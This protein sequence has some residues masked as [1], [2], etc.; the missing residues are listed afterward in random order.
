MDP[1][2]YHKIHSFTFRHQK[3]KKN[4]IFVLSFFSVIMKKSVSAL[5]FVSRIDVKH[6]KLLEG[7]YYISPPGRI[8]LSLCTFINSMLHLLKAWQNSFIATSSLDP[9]FCV[10][11]FQ[12]LRNYSSWFLKGR[13][14]S[15]KGNSTDTCWIS[16]EVLSLV[17]L[18]QQRLF[19]TEMNLTKHAFEGLILF[20]ACKLHN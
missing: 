14:S 19:F 11:F 20:G 6:I 9:S 1:L 15:W 13:S 2:L 7:L 3:V 4:H 16:T 8:S 17:T 18:C 10:L 12:C 5:Y